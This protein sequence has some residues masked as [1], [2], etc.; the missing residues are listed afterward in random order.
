MEGFEVGPLVLSPLVLRP[1]ESYYSVK[2][3]EKR[4][5]PGGEWEDKRGIVAYIFPFIKSSL[6]A[7][8]MDM[9][10]LFRDVLEPAGFQLGHRDFGD[11]PFLE[12]NA[13]EALEILAQK[14]EA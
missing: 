6:T 12:C 4:Q 13:K 7:N 11:N 2:L 14:A 9:I 1:N 8:R 3:T 10:G 5:A